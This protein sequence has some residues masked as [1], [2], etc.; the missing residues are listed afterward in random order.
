MTEG[1]NGFI[2]SLIVGLFILVP[3]GIWK[4]VELIIWAIRH[5]RIGLV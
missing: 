3:L 1:L 4:L 2:T 5:V